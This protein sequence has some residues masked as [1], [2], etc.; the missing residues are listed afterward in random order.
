ML[1]KIISGGQT[2]V[3]IAALEAAKDLGIETGGTMPK[4]FRT[5]TGNRPEYAE[6]YGVVEYFSPAYSPRTKKNVQDSDGTLLLSFVHDSPGQV[7]T[8]GHAESCGK[9]QYQVD[10]GSPPDASEVA[11]WI[12]HNKIK[13]LNVA[14]NSESTWPG[15]GE[16]AKAYL[17][18]VFRAV[19]EM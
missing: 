10:L 3:D 11:K 13:T 14:G 15:V 9:L 19:Q 2:G 4:G 8:L 17:L 6:M 1:S 12:F 16:I 18:D 7:C 5:L